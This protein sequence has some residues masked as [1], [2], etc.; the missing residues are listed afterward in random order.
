MHGNVEEWCH[1]WY[2]PYELGEEVD[3]VGRVDGDF[4]VTR[5]GS[6]STELYYLR[7]ANRSGA[8]PEDKS[9]VIGFRVVMGDFP[10]TEPRPIPKPQMFQENV[11][12]AVPANVAKGPDPGKPYFKGPR[13]YV[14]IEPDSYGPRFS[15]H[16]HDPGIVECPNGDLLAIWYSCVT[17]PGREVALL[18]SRLRYGAEEWEPS[19][20]FFDTPDRN[21]HAPALWFDGKETLYHFSGVSVADTYGPLALMMRT[22]RDNGVTWSKARLLDPEHGPRRMPIESVFRMSDGTIVMPSDARNSASTIWLS[23]DEGQNWKEAGGSIA[24]IHAGVVQL[25][26]GRLMALGRGN[27]VRG[28]MPKSIS[29]DRGQTW[30]YSATPFPPISGGQRLVLIRLS[31]G[32]LFLAS[33]AD[34]GIQITDSSGQNRQV[35][36]LFAAISYDEG[37]TWDIRRPVSDDGPGRYLVGGAWTGRFWM[38]LSHA[39][40]RGYLAVCQTADGVIHLISSAQHYAFNLAWLKAAAPAVPVAGD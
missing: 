35:S 40:P 31:E 34:K 8:L 15:I 39:E 5:G 13:R 30:E 2:G 9:W 18:A 23:E 37:E 38:G 10:E 14:K 33:F 11:S 6:H 26:D 20:L 24:G 12:Q 27:N 3:P 32:P 4:R 22:S 19:S 28:M 29:T 36:G 1:D 17:E 7:S 25:K 16:N 21:D